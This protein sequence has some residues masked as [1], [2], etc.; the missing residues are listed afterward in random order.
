MSRFRSLLGLLG[1]AWL[2][3]AGCGGDDAPERR[4]LSAEPVAGELH[5]VSYEAYGESVD[6]IV[7]LLNEYWSE[8]LPESFDTPYAPPDQVI[9]YQ[10]GEDRPE[11]DGEPLSAE[12]A[13][14]CPSS[15]TIA[16]DE[17]GL[18]IPFYEEVGDAAVGFVLAH[19]WGHLI[20]SELDAGFERTI[21]S[22]LNADCLAGTFAR[23]LSDE[24]LLDG[25]KS[26]EPGTDLAEAAKGIF[27]LGD[28]PATPWQD[29]DAHGTGDQR[30]RAFEI[31]FDGGVKACAHK[32][33][34]GFIERV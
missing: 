29:P 15:D 27:Y 4:P 28:A 32:L 8:A 25:G 7:G 21:E 23:A 11:C 22:E 12:N 5:G 33:G 24:G 6:E 2:A 1:V 18:M 3:A 17:E 30:Q 31:G 9:A 13:F 19:E 14:Y 20:Q 26:L 34:P 10:P 16:W